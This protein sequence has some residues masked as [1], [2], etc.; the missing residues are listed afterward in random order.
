[1]S[2]N[3]YAKADYYTK[4]ALSEKYPARSVY[5]LQEI[6]KKFRILQGALRVLDLGCA[7]GSWSMYL[8]R[9][10][11]KDALV[12][13]CDLQ[14]MAQNIQD[15]RLFFIQGDMTKSE[16]YEKIAFHSPFDAV[17]CDAAPY[18]TGNKTIDTV[19][20]HELVS[21]A[22]MYAKKTLKAGGNF[23]VKVFQGG[24]EEEILK[25]LKAAFTD[26]KAFKPKAC[27]AKSV[28]TYIIAISFKGMI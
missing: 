19:K 2:Q 16:T 21:L 28:E 6:D 24:G 11:K 26:V 20:Q 15:S 10:L 1:M 12:V 3:E 9:T 18:T 27:R 14:E 7:P 4:K 13:S 23:V 8:L 22:A 25:D 5:K 17:V